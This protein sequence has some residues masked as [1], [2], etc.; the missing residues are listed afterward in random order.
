MRTRF[1]IHAAL[2]G[3]M[4]AVMLTPAA[5]TLLPGRLPLPSRGFLND[6]AGTALVPLGIWTFV[7]VFLGIVNRK[8]DDAQGSVPRPVRRA[9]ATL[10]V[11]ACA[12]LVVQMATA[13]NLQSAAVR[14]GH[15][16]ARE[17][18]P[19]RR[20]EPGVEF[21]VSRQEYAEL[22]EAGQ[23][24]MLVIPGLVLAF[25]TLMGVASSALAPPAQPLPRA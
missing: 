15:Y 5:L 14:E 19:D 18:P 23:R 16:Y 10:L 22:R 3:G 1:K 21:E 9:V 11:A 8:R 6:I 17:A 7:E 25:L 2:S 20:S 24:G 13:G 4:S 12:L